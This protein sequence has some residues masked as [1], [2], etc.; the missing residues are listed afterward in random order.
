MLS[1]ILRSVW[2]KSCVPGRVA[3]KL[4]DTVILPPSRMSTES[5][6]CGAWPYDGLVHVLVAIAAVR[7]VALRG[8][9][10][11]LRGAVAERAGPGARHGHAVLGQAVLV[12]RPQLEPAQRREQRCDL[13]GE[14]TLANAPSAGTAQF[15]KG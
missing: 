13:G 14:S 5:A 1:E 10:E 7:R 11:A 12:E 6:G 4:A 9:T 8:E 2:Q 3:P 15:R